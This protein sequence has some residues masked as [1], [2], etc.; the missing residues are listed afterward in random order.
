M[1]GHGNTPPADIRGQGGGMGH[2]SVVT[3]RH[4]HRPEVGADGPVGAGV[5]DTRHE[6]LNVTLN[7]VL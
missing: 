5:A 2:W 4:H 3:H 7:T 1:R 6:E